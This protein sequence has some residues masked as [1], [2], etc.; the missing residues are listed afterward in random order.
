[1]VRSSRSRSTGST[2][3][4][5]RLPSF[6]SDGTQYVSGQQGRHEHKFSLSIGFIERTSDEA[7]AFEANKRMVAKRSF[8]IL[9]RRCEIYETQSQRQTLRIAILFD[10]FAFCGFSVDA[11]VF[12]GSM[13][14]SNYR[15]VLWTSRYGQDPPLLH[16]LP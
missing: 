11:F 9:L 7:K 3:A 13:L 14:S 8:M 12:C 5:R 2:T 10:M 1:M 15:Y 6:Y 16:S 4:P